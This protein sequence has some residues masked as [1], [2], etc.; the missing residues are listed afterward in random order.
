MVSVLALFQVSQRVIHHSLSV[1]LV[2]SILRR[3]IS[4]W[5]QDSPSS[6]SPTFTHFHSKRTEFVLPKAQTE[7]PEFLLTCSDWADWSHMTIPGPI[8]G[9]GRTWWSDWPALDYIFPLDSDS[10][11]SLTRITQTENRG[12]LFLELGRLMSSSL[13]LCSINLFSLFCATHIRH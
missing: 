6:T 12:G 4:S 9:L 7:V 11:L 3:H 5:T 2:F 13:L 10:G 1:P 8:T